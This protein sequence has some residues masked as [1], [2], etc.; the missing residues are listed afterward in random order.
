MVNKDPEDVDEGSLP[1][2]AEPIARDTH[3]NLMVGVYRTTED[4]VWVLQVFDWANRV[5]EATVYDVDLD[6]PRT[7]GAVSWESLDTPEEMD[8][9]AYLKEK[10][11]NRVD[12]LENEEEA[13]A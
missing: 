7:E 5:V 3:D 12:A 2:T 13:A 11:Q 6:E 9:E 1:E 8:H 10:L 4:D